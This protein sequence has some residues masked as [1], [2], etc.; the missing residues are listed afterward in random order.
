MIY[1]DK[2]F[3]KRRR[4]RHGHSEILTRPL[5]YTELMSS[6]AFQRN[7]EALKQFRPELYRELSTAIEKFETQPNAEIDGLTYQLVGEGPYLQ[8]LLITGNGTHALH[9]FPNPVTELEEVF[10]KAKVHTP[11]LILFFGVGLGHALARFLQSKTAFTY[12]IFVVEKDPHVFVR[13]LN[14]YDF[15]EEIKNPLNFWLVSKPANNVKA[16]MASFMRSH[17][18]VTRNLKV[19]GQPFSLQTAQEYYLEI[20]SYVGQARD[21]ATI[22]SGNSV[23]D[24]LHG[25]QNQ[26]ANLKRIIE[27][28]GIGFLAK[29]FEGQTCLSVAAGP[30]TNEAWDFI[31]SAQGRI[32]I[33]CCDT[34]LKP[35]NDRG[36][37]PDIVTAL[38]RDSIVADMMRG[39]KVD[40]KSTLVAPTLLLPDSF[41]C[42]KGRHLIYGVTTAYSLGLALTHLTN[43]YPGSSAGNLNLA[44]ATFMGFSRVIMIGHN[45]AFALNSNESHLK[46][47]F[48]PDREI[49]KTE[50]EIARK[51]TGGKVPTADGLNEVYTIREYNLFRE[52]I[53][54][55]IAGNPS[56]KYI[57]TT[58]KGARISG[59]EFRPLKEI[60]KELES[61]QFNFWNSFQPLLPQ[62]SQTEIQ[63]RFQRLIPKLL[64]SLEEFSQTIKK[65]EETL[66]S[67]KVWKEEIAK[68]E[69][70][71]GQLDM[72]ELNRMLDE[73]LDLKLSMAFRSVNAGPMI[74]GVMAPFNA[75]FERI[76]NELPH[77]HTSNYELRKDVLL[78]HEDYFKSWLKWLPKIQIEVEKAYEELKSIPLE[79]P[80]A[81][82]KQKTQESILN[83][84]PR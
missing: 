22:W 61:Y 52:Q 51:A 39:Q 69:S 54:S 5:L 83:P 64:G 16:H 68:A 20:S 6:I 82:T 41:E 50:D 44:I 1:R 56:T 66:Q 11:Q 9:H 36:I 70:G 27:N 15:S 42:F 3:F 55:L 65:T 57:N 26:L 80:E 38:E 84:N 74:T 30:G 71:G 63:E 79:L 25:I 31:R 35:M 18:T 33:I 8:N 7:I 46:G 60:E 23:N 45:L 81:P 4:V 73:A 59:S 49:T 47:T 10:G 2:T 29:K 62:Q 21:Q 77:T 14:L 58:A 13:A 43:L 19:I 48:D 78:K 72:T 24:S 53:E 12:G 76:I 17:N 28:P 75:A 67:Y 32:P 37:V 34:L 40:S